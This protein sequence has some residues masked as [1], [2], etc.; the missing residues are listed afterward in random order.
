[1]EPTLWK[2]IPILEC[3]RASWNVFAKADK[4]KP[5]HSAILKGLEKLEKWYSNVK[6]SDAYLTSL[7]SSLSNVVRN[8]LMFE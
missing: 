6:H 4:F 8:L 1:M 5:L 2:A 3:I 7:G